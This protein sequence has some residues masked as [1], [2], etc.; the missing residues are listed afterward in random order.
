MTLTRRQILLLATL[1]LLWGCNWPAMKFSLREVPPLTFRALT[2]TAGVSLMAVWFALRGTSLALPRTQIA[3]VFGLAVPSIIGW[4]LASIIGLTQLAAGRAGILAFTM[5]VWTVL[6]GALLF[7]QR[8]TQRAG[9]ASLCALAAVALLALDELTSLAGRPVGVLWLQAA[10]MSWA[11]GTLLLK[12]ISVSLSTE[13]LTVWMMAFGCVFFAAAALALEPLPA[14]QAWSAATWASLAWGALINFGISQLLWFMLARELPAQV[15]AFS[16]MAVPMVGVLS[17][18]L[19]VGE[20]PR[21]S[22]WIAVLFIGAAIA[23]ATGVKLRSRRSDNA[24]R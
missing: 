20:S 19:I 6:L 14:P 5:P 10:A 8:L 11:L 22:D 16:L 21:I 9:I 15:S 1:S 23:A 7:G 24:G 2:M 18:A 17:S 13:A 12:R 4:H 3:R